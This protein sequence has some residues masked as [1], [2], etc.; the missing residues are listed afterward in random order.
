MSFLLF[1]SNKHYPR[2]GAEDL[3][4]AFHAPSDKDIL[5]LVAGLL[6][7]GQLENDNVIRVNGFSLEGNA[8]KETLHWEFRMEK[9]LDSSELQFCSVKEAFDDLGPCGLVPMTAYVDE[10]TTPGQPTTWLYPSLD[11]EKEDSRALW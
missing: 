9:A 10:D 3:I 8:L 6:R 11:S 1:A 2:G 5:G 4:G 7:S